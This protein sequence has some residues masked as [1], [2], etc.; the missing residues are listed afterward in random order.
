VSDE[1]KQQLTHQT[2]I[3]Q[4]INVT[5]H[6]SPSSLSG[7]IKVSPNE[8]KGYPFPAFINSFLTKFPAF[9]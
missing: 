1:V 7:F 5:L 6:E 4:F 9:M 2:I 3:G 8:I